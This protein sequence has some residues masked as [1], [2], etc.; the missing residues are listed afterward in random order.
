[1][2][3]LAA[4]A[5]PPPPPTAGFEGVDGSEEENLNEQTPATAAAPSQITPLQFQLWKRQKVCT[6]VSEREC[7]SFS[8]EIKPL[9][10]SS[11][12][13]KHNRKIDTYSNWDGVPE[14]NGLGIFFYLIFHSHLQPAAIHWA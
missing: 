5:A 9:S 8:L 10:L 1:M 4:A 13:E 3:A 12:S 11:F 2:G 6:C 14:H 7:E